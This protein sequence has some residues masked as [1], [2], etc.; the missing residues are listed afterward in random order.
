[1]TRFSVGIDEMAL[2]VPPFALS[3]DALAEARQ[4]PRDKIRIGL[5]AHAMAV[6]PPWEDTVTLGANA[7]ARLFAG[8]RD[9]K[10]IY[11]RAEHPA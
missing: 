5:G 10:R 6:A 3:L 1:M 2:Y 7:A 8:V 11:E 9:H 4:V